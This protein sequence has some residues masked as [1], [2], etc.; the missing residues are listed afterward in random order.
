LFFPSSLF[1]ASF[2]R[3]FQT[4]KVNF[5]SACG[6]ETTTAG[7][8]SASL[9]YSVSGGSK[10]FVGGATAYTT[11]SWRVWGGWTDENVVSYHGPTPELVT[12]LATNVRER[13]DV[14]YCIGEWGAAGP[15]VLGLPIV[16]IVGQT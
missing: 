15:T 13:M 16:H 12:E 10:C 9:P 2:K 4:F 14:A 8:V 5:I 7:L 11:K 1:Q 3:D 6:A